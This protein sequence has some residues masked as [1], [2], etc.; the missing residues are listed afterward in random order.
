[1]TLQHYDGRDYNIM[2]KNSNYFDGIRHWLIKV[3]IQ[4]SWQ[5]VTFK[6]KA[7]P[8]QCDLGSKVSR[9]EPLVIPGFIKCIVF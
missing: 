6:A 4:R 3:K 2:K 8:D 1:M 7:G 5:D 9:T